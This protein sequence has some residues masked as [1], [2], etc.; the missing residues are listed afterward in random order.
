MFNEISNQ[1]IESLDSVDQKRFNYIKESIEQS[2][3]VSPSLIRHFSDLAF[4]LAKQSLRNGKSIEITEPL[5]SIFENCIN[6]TTGTESNARINYLI[7]ETKLDFLYASGNHEISSL[8]LA[9]YL[10]AQNNQPP[11]N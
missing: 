1:M 6:S 2:S 7:S 11:K 4:S 10:M 5:E 8:R 3:P 9:P